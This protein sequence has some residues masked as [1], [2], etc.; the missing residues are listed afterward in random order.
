MEIQEVHIHVTHIPAGVCI[1]V[2]MVTGGYCT[3]PVSLPVCI[4]HEA[5][6]LLRSHATLTSWD[7]R[8]VT[9]VPHP[10]FPPSLIRPLSTAQPIT[11]IIAVT[12]EVHSQHC[13]RDTGTQRDFWSVCV[14]VFD[15][16][17][18]CHTHTHT[19]L[20]ARKDLS[21]LVHQPLVVMKNSGR[22]MMKARMTNMK[23]LM[24]A[25]FVMSTCIQTH[26]LSLRCL[27]PA[28]T[29]TRLSKQ[30]F[31]KRTSYSLLRNC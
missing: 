2:C 18:H 25:G 8:G 6:R 19:L 29:D 16:C 12:V 17:E 27:L 23:S 4:V 7:Q 10:T 5:E 31:D 11:G 30:T 9:Q 20:S 21:L 13:W 24:S 28:S 14:H 26:N 1:G 15:E 22:Q 3:L